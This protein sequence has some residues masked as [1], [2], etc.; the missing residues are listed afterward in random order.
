MSD[1][2]K[3]TE[4]T[5]NGGYET[6]NRREK[7]NVGVS[8]NSDHDKNLYLSNSKSVI[9]WQTNSEDSSLAL[10]TTKTEI[11]EAADRDLTSVE[12]SR[13]LFG[14]SV[15]ARP[16]KEVTPE[17]SVESMTD[18]AAASDTYDKLTEA[19]VDREDQDNPSERGHF[20]LVD[21]RQSYSLYKEGED[22]N[23]F[24]D[25]RELVSDL[26]GYTSEQQDAIEKMLIPYQRLFSYEVEGAGS[27]EHR[28]R[29]RIPKVIVRWSYPVPFALRD[30]VGK[31][32][33]EM[34]A[35]GI[36]ERS[37]SQYCNPLRIVEKKDGRI[38]VCLDARFIN[39]AIESDNESPPIIGEIL[40]KYHGI[41]YMST[42]DLAYGYWQIPLAVESRPYTAFLYDS[43]LYQ[44]CRIP[45]GLKTAGSGFI[46]ALNLA[47]GSEFDFFLT[48]YIDDLLV[49]SKSFDEHLSHLKLLFSKLQ[50]QNFTLRLD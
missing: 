30:A 25:V 3:I 50:D 9:L 41:E 7:E 46:R 40:Q 23:F 19:M 2:I 24:K 49:T 10:R 28:I 17:F 35:A 38:R 39:N 34:L 14:R 6:A 20:E 1:K 16:Y 27:Y 26:N 33:T 47:L 18:A 15:N 42:T 31:E 48:C 11:T 4:P 37:D 36:I 21:A 45:F 32:I 5:N 29:L 13:A 43:K 12:D 44:F 22:E 8:T